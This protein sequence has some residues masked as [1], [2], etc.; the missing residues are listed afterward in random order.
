[1]QIASELEKAVGEVLAR[2][3]SDPRAKGMITV[4]ALD[5]T[6]DLSIAKVTVSVMPEEHEQITMHALASASGFVRREVMKRVHL[7]EMPVLMFRLDT[8]LKNQAKV[9]ELLNKI[10]QERVER[11]ESAEASSD[12]GAES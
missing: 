3:L 12:A 9:F 1:L 6:E 8:G 11:G 10:A 4:T 7:R 5:L 2:G